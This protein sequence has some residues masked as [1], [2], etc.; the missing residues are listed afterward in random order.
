MN[1]QCLFAGCI[2]YLPAKIRELYLRLLAESFPSRLDSNGNLIQTHSSSCLTPREVCSAVTQGSLSN[3]SRPN[4]EQGLQNLLRRKPEDPP[5]YPGAFLRALVQNA[6]E[7]LSRLAQA[8]NLG[9]IK[10][11]QML[12][13]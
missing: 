4:K 12:N 13:Y 5:M 2:V 6:T 3:H 9:L 7:L 8:T 11:E 10:R 1:A